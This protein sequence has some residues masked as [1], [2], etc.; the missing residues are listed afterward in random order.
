MANNAARNAMR[1]AFRDYLGVNVVTANLATDEGVNSLRKLM[2][3]ERADIERFDKKMNKHAEEADNVNWPGGGVV[4]TLMDIRHVGVLRRICNLDLATVIDQDEFDIGL[5]CREEWKLEAT[6]A[7]EP[8]ELFQLRSIAKD[9]L[10]F[11]N[12]LD[13]YMNVKLGAAGI[14]LA[15]LY[16]DKEVPD[17]QDFAEQYGSFT[18]RY[19][20]LA[21]LNGAHARIDNRQLFV[22]LMDVTS[23][24]QG[25]EFVRP[26]EDTKNGRAAVLALKAQAEGPSF[27]DQRIQNAL[28]CT[29]ESRY[30]GRKGF[31]F[32]QYIKVHQQAHNEL[33]ACQYPIHWPTMIQVFLRNITSEAGLD[34]VKQQALADPVHKSNFNEC[35][36][37]LRQIVCNSETVARAKSSRTISAVQVGRKRGNGKGEGGKQKLPWISNEEYQALS[38]EEKK[39]YRSA[40]KQEQKPRAKRQKTGKRGGK[41]RE[42]SAVNAGDESSIDELSPE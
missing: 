16:R 6:N 27:V 11:W 9:W 37:H 42:T 30:K 36:Q 20:A 3:M 2:Q 41:P 10:K 17:A 19:K 22:C 4:P 13:A 39:K 23:E 8:P 40:R 12:R 28:A 29:E 18:E 25:W 26:F 21:S 5:E 7:G 38:A 32:D 14:P 1:Q 15:Y 31:T 24:G 35:Q 33:R 34:S